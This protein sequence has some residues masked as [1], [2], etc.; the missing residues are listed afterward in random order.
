MTAWLLT[1]TFYG[2]WLPGDPRGSVTNVRDRRPDDP[3]TPVRLE[4]ARPGDDY[5]DAIPGLQR[6]SLEQLKGPP[7]ALD[8]AQAE[9][10]LDQ[11]LET[12]AHRRWTLHA[13]SIMFNHFHMVLEAPPKVGKKVLLRDIK[14]YGSRRLN[15]VFGPRE[16]GTWWSDGGSCR[17]IRNR[18]AA[19]YYTCHRQPHPLV[20]WSRERGR[21]PPAESDPENVYP[22]EPPDSEP[23]D[24]E[25]P[26]SE[27][28]ALAG[29][30]T[31][32]PR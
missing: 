21:I 26:D 4:H 11:F 8:L 24:S 28:P 3:A 14:S 13:V 19:I 15:R 7:V 12:A 9:Q 16:A 27:P 20:V 31:Y 23:P 18:S 5:E 17:P 30:A 22:G 2:Q 29:G 1:S 32:S 10:L 6:A 25:P